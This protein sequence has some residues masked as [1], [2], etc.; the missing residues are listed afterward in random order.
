MFDVGVLK[1]KQMSVYAVIVAY[2]RIEST[3]RAIDS[4][5]VS[6]D[7]L[8]LVL[9]DNSGNDNFFNTLKNKLEAR[10]VGRILY[11]RN[12]Q[13]VGFAK[14]VNQGIRLSLRKGADYVLLLNDDAYVDKNCI[15]S[16]IYALS[17]HEQSLL[18]GPTIFYEKHKDKVWSAGGYYNKLLGKISMPLK[19]K[20]VDPNILR[21]AEVREVGFLTGCVLVIKSKAFGKV[22]FFD[23]DFFFY[24]EDVDYCLRTAKS[25][26]K[27]LWVPYAFAWHDIDIIHG[28]TNSFAMYN[29]ARSS[30]TLGK[31]N[32]ST[33]YYI[34]Y[35]LL[36]FLLHTPYR[37]YQIVVGRK[38]FNV[39]LS[40]FKGIID[41]MQA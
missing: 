17:N 16:L 14:A 26:F 21:Q 11:I 38:N 39:I 13:N 8:K 32:F 30:I 34:Y 33:I 23:E 31:K 10:H 22:G 7:E 1:M 2:N 15:P 36:R 27:M 41:G 4:A 5:I 3:L 18:A 29:I 37:V 12:E 20:K 9:V 24:N 28:R 6:Y 19:N 40:W 25:G 35:V